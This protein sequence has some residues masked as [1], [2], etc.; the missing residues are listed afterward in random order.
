LQGWPCIARRRHARSESVRTPVSFVLS[1]STPHTLYSTTTATPLPHTHPNPPPPP[2]PPSPSHHHLT[3]SSPPRTS[4]HN[5]KWPRCPTDR[6]IGHMQNVLAHCTSLS[7]LASTLQNYME[8]PASGWAHNSAAL[9]VGKGECAIARFSCTLVG[10]RVRQCHRWWA[11]QVERGRLRNEVSQGHPT[12][13]HALGL[14]KST[15][16]HGTSTSPCS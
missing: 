10:E 15:A 3:S 2:P 8:Q 14:A 11:T 5:H 9:A 13:T 12:T 6:W 16:G 4:V 7:P 1:H